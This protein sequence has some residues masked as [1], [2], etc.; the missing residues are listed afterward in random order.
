[1]R[2]GVHFLRA[3]F[4]VASLDLEF[5]AAKAQEDEKEVVSM[6][7][8]NSKALVVA[9]EIEVAVVVDSTNSEGPQ[10]AGFPAAADRK[11]AVVAN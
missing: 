10:Y 2:G 6:A 1:M 7:G 8:G 4:G 11:G 9:A 5:L 3:S